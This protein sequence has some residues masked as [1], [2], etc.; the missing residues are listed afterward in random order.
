MNNLYYYWSTSM[1]RHVS[2]SRLARAS[3]ELQLKVSHLSTCALLRL[4]ADRKRE[5]TTPANSRKSR[6]SEGRRSAVLSAGEELHLT[7]YKR[8][9]D[10]GESE[11]STWISWRNHWFTSSPLCFL[12]K[13]LSKNLHW[14]GTGENFGFYY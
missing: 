5:V 8:A 1:I 12:F 13:S 14:R 7:H 3:D 10:S 9:K 4:T 2:R 6:E 11:M